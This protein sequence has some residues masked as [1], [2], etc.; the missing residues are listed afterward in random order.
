[1]TSRG[2]GPYTGLCVIFCFFVLY[3][4]YVFRVNTPP[5]RGAVGGVTFLSG[6]LSF[7]HLTPRNANDP[8]EVFGMTPP[9]C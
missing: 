2:T 7:P 3:L 1:M 5:H 4:F 8:R 9:L 6:Y